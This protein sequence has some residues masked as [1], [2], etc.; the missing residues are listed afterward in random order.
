ME[1]AFVGRPGGRILV[2]L[3]DLGGR[4]EVRVK[5][6]GLGTGAGN[7]NDNS[8]GLNIVRMLVAEDL[9]GTFE[10]KRTGRAPPR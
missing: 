3:N 1:H 7:M 6:D 2:N 4:L 10:I 9:R 8:L 5:D